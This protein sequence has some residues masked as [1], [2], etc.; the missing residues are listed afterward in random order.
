[1]SRGLKKGDRVYLRMSDGHTYTG[2]FDGTEDKWGITFL[3]L[4]YNGRR[5]V[6]NSKHLLGCGKVGG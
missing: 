5:S 1:M 4:Y 3:L 6:F 2:I